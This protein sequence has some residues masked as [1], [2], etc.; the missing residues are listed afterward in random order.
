ME[1]IFCPDSRAHVTSWVGA[2]VGKGAKCPSCVVVQITAPGPIP[3]PACVYCEEKKNVFGIT[4]CRNCSQMPPDVIANLTKGTPKPPLKTFRTM[5]NG[6]GEFFYEHICTAIDYRPAASEAEAV[7][8]PQDDSRVQ[9]LEI[10]LEQRG[11][12]VEHLTQENQQLREQLTRA[13]AKTSP[14]K[15]AGKQVPETKPA[16]EVAPELSQLSALGTLL[17]KFDKQQA[18]TREVSQ[19]NGVLSEQV[20]SLTERLATEEALRAQAE[21]ALQELSPTGPAA[22]T[23]PHLTHAHASGSS[24]ETAISLASV[25]PLLNELQVG[26]SRLNT[27]SLESFLSIVEL[28]IRQPAKAAQVR[29]AM[30][31]CVRVARLVGASKAVTF[32]GQ[33]IKRKLEED[34]EQCLR[35][36]HDLK[37]IYLKVEKEE[38]SGGLMKEI[39]LKLEGDSTA[40]DGTVRVIGYL[41]EVLPPS[42]LTELTQALFHFLGNPSEETKEW[43]DALSVIPL[44]W[45]EQY[46]EKA[47]QGIRKLM[48]AVIKMNFDAA[49]LQLLQILNTY[50]HADPE[51]LFIFISRASEAL[52]SERP[53]IHVQTLVTKLFIFLQLEVSPEMSKE[54]DH[55]SFAALRVYFTSD[56]NRETVALLMCILMALEKSTHSGLTWLY[57]DGK[58]GPVEHAL[59][60]LR[61]MQESGTELVASAEVADKFFSSFTSVQGLTAAESLVFIKATGHLC[62][63]KPTKAQAIVESLTDMMSNAAAHPFVNEIAQ[64]SD[65]N[66]AKGHL[67]ETRKLLNTVRRFPTDAVLPTARFLANTILQLRKAGTTVPILTRK[68]KMVL[69]DKTNNLKQMLAAIRPLMKSEEAAPSLVLKMIELLPEQ[70]DD[71]VHLLSFVG[72]LANSL[73]SF[74]LISNETAIHFC[75]D[76]VLPC[77]AT[78][79]VNLLVMMH[80][81]LQAAKTN[82]L[83]EMLRNVKRK[84]TTLDIYEQC[85][86]PSLQPDALRIFDCARLEA[87]TIRLEQMIKVDTSSSYAFVDEGGIICCGGSDSS[88]AKNASASRASSVRPRIGLLPTELHRKGGTPPQH[89]RRPQ[90]PRPP[91]LLQVQRPLRLRRQFPARRQ[92]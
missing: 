64:L 16:P 26:D 58:A 75:E 65:I 9:K 8:A 57:G 25:I 88:G 61:L 80:A 30:K 4:V 73:A 29:K 45:E 52:R 48:A 56:T 33:A 59:K 51:P 55:K 66:E 12:E 13:T 49:C 67:V 78:E 36:V 72:D 20:R 92:T 68:L 18:Q 60:L 81:Q 71:Q 91:L 3:P 40:F 6:L 17:E 46:R 28:G 39:L 70:P 87:K 77:F 22:T 90:L 24:H 14:A 63:A 5:L 62:E 84:F 23:T 15:P 37:R 2:G 34:P 76:A 7:A 38:G 53:P 86:L 1:S 74:A 47:V 89:A 85:M 32:F 82:Y 69:L 10:L 11:K 41:S 79:N 42:Q 54:L 27:K 19:E 35:L 21:A 31:T 83:V 50:T 44:Q 43:L